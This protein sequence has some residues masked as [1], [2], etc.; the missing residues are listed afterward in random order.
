VQKTQK[1][2]NQNLEAGSQQFHV[3]M[4][5]HYNFTN[6]KA[7]GTFT[8]FTT[9]LESNWEL[10]NTHLDSVPDPWHF[11]N[12]TDPHILLPKNTYLFKDS[13][14][15]HCRNCAEFTGLSGNDI[16]I[17]CE[18]KLQNQKANL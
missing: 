4:H 6:S 7:V 13:S 9:P 1:V 15:I 11:R 17:F 3:R 16:G 14:T 12:D 8:V 2:V 10:D 18:R 5:Y